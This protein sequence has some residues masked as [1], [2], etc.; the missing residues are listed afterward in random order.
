MSEGPSVTTREAVLGSLLTHAC[1][2][3]YVLLFPGTFAPGPPLVHRPAEDE[4]RIPVSFQAPE[5][6]QP[7]LALGDSGRMKS[8]EPRPP[9]APPPTN[10]D[11]YSV[12]NTRNR[13]VAPPL[14][15]KTT[16]AMEPGAGPL[17]KNEGASSPADTQ[18]EQTG[19]QG[20]PD[21]G[22]PD[23]PET[24][25][26]VPTAPGAGNTAPQRG[27]RDGT[28]RDALGRMSMGMSGGGAPLKFDNPRGGVSGPMGGLSFETKDFDWGPYA[29]RIYW[30]IW[31]NWMRGWPPAAWAGLKGTVGVRF[32]IWK[33][34]HIS[35]IEVMTPSGTEAFD[36]C[37]TLALEASSPLPAL[38]ADFTKESEGITARFLYNTDVVD[39]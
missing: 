23:G 2:I 37:A 27:S 3:I 16:A 39:E 11:P 7:S 32:R 13:F 8:S 1:I 29:R 18:A 35:G 12:G 19:A 5:Q 38:P 6:E 22:A 31:S 28:L 33:D 34:G 26:A 17:P 9:T 24:G 21:E 4:Q 10:N 20:Q 30:I 36:T 14:P 25:G 15:A